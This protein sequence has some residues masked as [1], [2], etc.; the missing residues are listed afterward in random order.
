LIRRRARLTLETSGGSEDVVVSSGPD[1]W[2]V[3]R[4]G[5]RT[6]VDLA[7]LPD[8]R[9]SLVLEDGRQISGRVQPGSGR[10]EV[11]VSTRNGDVRVSIEDAVRH[12]LATTGDSDAGSGEEVRALMPG[13]VL[14]VAARPG[15]SVLPG[16]V[17]LVL[18]AM[19]M[20]NEIR[21]SS[22]GTIT[23]VEVS[24]GQAVETG[25]LMVSIAPPA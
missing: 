17:L 13:R 21:C 18:E 8:G 15:E 25:F 12:R 11:L 10:G 14:E 24:P 19:K 16:A 3:E 9:V 1:G 4:G 2:A 5:V 6:V 23:R 20:Q 7:K 22:A